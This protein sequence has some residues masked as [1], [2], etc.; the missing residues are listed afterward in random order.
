MEQVKEEILE[1]YRNKWLNNV[2]GDWELEFVELLD[3]A[4]DRIEAEAREETLNEAIARIAVD[5]ME[6]ELMKGH[7]G[8]TYNQAHVHGL[9]RAIYLILINH[10][11]KAKYTK[12]ETE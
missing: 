2:T 4:F 5:V 11:L 6:V 7:K 10:E 8:N 3:E 9:K 12:G 1:E